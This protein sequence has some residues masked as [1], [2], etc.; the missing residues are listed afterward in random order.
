MVSGGWPATS[1]LGASTRR[2]FSSSSL[3][4]IS[5]RPRWAHICTAAAGFISPPDKGGTQWHGKEDERLDDGA[6]EANPE[7]HG[8]CMRRTNRQKSML[9][10]ETH[11][12]RAVPLRKPTDRVLVDPCANSIPG[13]MDEDGVERRKFPCAGEQVWRARVESNL[14]PLRGGSGLISN[15]R[16]NMYTVGESSWPKKSRSVNSSQTG[17]ERGRSSLQRGAKGSHQ[18]FHPRRRP[19]MCQSI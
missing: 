6:G 11:R 8:L 9:T 4:S 17:G 12:P 16:S 2:G 7:C 5:T 19:R 10:P 15:S 14:L 3:S 13:T 18:E 1:R